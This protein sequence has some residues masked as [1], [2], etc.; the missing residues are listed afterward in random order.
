[1]RSAWRNV[2]ETSL[3][4]VGVSSKR[5]NFAKQLIF[6]SKTTTPLG[7]LPKLGLLAS[8]L[9]GNFACVEALL[10]ETRDGGGE[11]HANVREK[12][13]G[14]GFEVFVHADGKGSCHCRLSFL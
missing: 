3:T 9:E 10:E 4:T 6:A 5:D 1:M 14:I 11:V 2:S 7:S 8:E 12:L 13:L